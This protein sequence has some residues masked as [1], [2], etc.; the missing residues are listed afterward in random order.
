M[1]GD[2]L[3]AESLE[4]PFIEPG[5]DRCRPA[6]RCQHALS[7]PAV[8]G[9]KRVSSSPPRVCTSGNLQDRFQAVK[10]Q[11]LHRF[12]GHRGDSAGASAGMI[13][14][15]HRLHPPRDAPMQRHP[16]A[17]MDTELPLGTNHE[18][19]GKRGALQPGPEPPA[20][21]LRPLR[22]VRTQRTG[23]TV[24]VRRR[25]E[26]Y[27][28]PD[29]LIRHSTVNLCCRDSMLQPPGPVLLHTNIRKPVTVD[30]D[31]RLSPARKHIRNLFPDRH[32]DSPHRLCLTL[33]SSHS[34]EGVTNFSQLYML[35]H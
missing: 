31:E 22:N 4:A 19:V 29:F 25:R 35:H 32:F 34:L 33:S 5:V 30:S 27:P 24:V 8:D 15:G 14:E 18:S 26:G 16:S 17:G 12:T 2:L 20:L 6:P 23:T 21:R 1:A 11:R 10:L 9:H 7:F 28:A 13:C 3:N